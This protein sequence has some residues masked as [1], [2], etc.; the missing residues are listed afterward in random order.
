MSLT[1]QNRKILWGLSGNRCAYPGC[2]QLLHL[3][4]GEKGTSLIGEEC[5]IEAQSGNGPRFSSKLTEKQIN[6]YSNL[7]LLCPTHHKRISEIF[8]VYVSV[9][10]MISL[11]ESS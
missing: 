8:E 5:H 11:E 1:V 2:N 7:I 6:H 4:V 3:E 9:H 10:E